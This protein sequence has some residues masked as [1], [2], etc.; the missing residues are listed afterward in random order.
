M[1]VRPPQSSEPHGGAVRRRRAAE[2]HAPSYQTRRMAARAPSVA[3]RP[4][5]ALRIAYLF[6]LGCAAYAPI[7]LA[8]LIVWHHDTYDQLTLMPTFA[9]EL[10]VLSWGI[11]GILVAVTH[12][13][14]WVVGVTEL[15]TRRRQTPAPRRRAHASVERR[16]SLEVPR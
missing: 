6:M 7:E 9:V 3:A 13:W 16:Q 2:P 1:Y 11:L 15:G 14:L 8:R 12:G 4:N 5:I 10:A